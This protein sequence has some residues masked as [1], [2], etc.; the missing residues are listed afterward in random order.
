MDHGFHRAA[1]DQRTG[2]AVNPMGFVIMIVGLMLVWMGFTGNQ[3]AIFAVISG[4][5]PAV[6][7]TPT[8]NPFN[9]PGMLGQ[10]ANNLNAT[11]TAPTASTPSPVAV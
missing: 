4:K 6:Q 2:N 7:N 10:L 9:I 1:S 5:A 8:I 11:T 3:A